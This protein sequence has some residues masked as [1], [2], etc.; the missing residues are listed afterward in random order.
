MLL[1]EVLSSTSVSPTF[2][3]ESPFGQTSYTIKL[4]NPFAR[5]H[6]LSCEGGLLAS[7]VKIASFGALSVCIRQPIAV[8][9]SKSVILRYNSCPSRLYFSCL[10]PL[11]GCK[12]KAPASPS[13]QGKVPG[14]YRRAH[15]C[16]VFAYYKVQQ[17]N[18][19]NR[20]Y[21][22]RHYYSRR[23]YSEI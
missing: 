10:R 3:R 8:R 21:S 5:S 7:G 17:Q 22:K 23:R 18:C 16:L 20:I 11:E 15:E 2:H 4:Y 1:V 13:P 19:K 12:G 14:P 6:P 9:M